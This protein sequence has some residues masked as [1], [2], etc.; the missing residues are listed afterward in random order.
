MALQRFTIVSMVVYFTLNFFII[1]SSV[2]IIVHYISSNFAFRALVQLRISSLNSAYFVCDK[3]H[4]FFS[5]DVHFL[6]RTDHS[7]S[8]LSDVVS[9]SNTLSS[10]SKTR[11][12]LAIPCTEDTFFHRTTRS[13]V[14]YESSM[15]RQK[16]MIIPLSL[17]FNTAQ[18][19]VSISNSRHGLLNFI[20]R[21]SHILIR[22]QIGSVSQLKTDV[23]M[24]WS[25]TS[26]REYFI[27][28]ANS[29]KLVS[30]V[31]HDCFS[32][33]ANRFRELCSLTLERSNFRFH[34]RT[35]R[36]YSVFVYSRV[37]ISLVLLRSLFKFSLKTL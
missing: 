7:A 19:S 2:L 4:I 25:R 12:E 1:S 33:S 14:V 22:N 5:V 29:I 13:Y 27:S 16:L 15:L 30:R 24:R 31:M 21:S 23:S 3:V 18:Q 10:C 26:S 9:R 28:R 6:R 20:V 37:F 34:S 17:S 8:F 35:S 36:S 11:V 32:L